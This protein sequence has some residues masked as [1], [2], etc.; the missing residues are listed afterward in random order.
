MGQRLTSLSFAAISL[1]CIMASVLSSKFIVVF[2]IL[3][4]S[5]FSWKNNINQILTNIIFFCGDWPILFWRQIYFYQRAFCNKVNPWPIFAKLW[6][7]MFFFSQPRALATAGWSIS[8]SPFDPW[9]MFTT[10]GLN[11]GFKII[12]I[13]DYPPSH[14]YVIW[15]FQGFSKYLWIS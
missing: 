13:L 12:E 2:D 14:N 9:H 1:S 8:Q 7:W 5:N 10:Q 4:H 11:F 3:G 15:N 6:L